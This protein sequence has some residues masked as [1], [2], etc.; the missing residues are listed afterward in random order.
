MIQCYHV[1]RQHM[2]PPLSGQFNRVAERIKETSGM[3]H[4]VS[5]PPSERGL[6]RDPLTAGLFHEVKVQCGLRDAPIPMP[7]LR[8]QRKV[9]SWIKPY[10]N[11]AGLRSGRDY[12]LS[13]QRS[14]A[15]GRFCK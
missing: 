2:S 12:T 3:R 8:P 15:G 6:E 7:E 14:I 5:L 13:S 10:A 1:L 9:L 11:R 4:Q